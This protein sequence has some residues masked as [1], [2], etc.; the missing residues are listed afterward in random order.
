[1]LQS[2]APVFSSGN[3]GEKIVGLF[4]VLSA[5]CALCE[6]RVNEIMSKPDINGCLVGGGSLSADCFA[7]PLL[8]PNSRH[9]ASR[10]PRRLSRL[11]Y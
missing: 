9:G 6:T 3:S 4:V 8:T 10:P 2:N 7:A 1:M 5:M 11:S